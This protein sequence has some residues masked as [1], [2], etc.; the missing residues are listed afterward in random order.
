M[1][2]V[3]LG[4]VMFSLFLC[5]ECGEGVENTLLS[6]ESPKPR[7]CTPARIMDRDKNN[8]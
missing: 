7:S 8:C 1:S 2:D 3:S 6:S 4:G 5:L